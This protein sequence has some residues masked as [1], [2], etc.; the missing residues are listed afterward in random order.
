[1]KN[2]IASLTLLFTFN[3]VSACIPAA[4]EQYAVLD[5]SVV[6]GH[7]ALRDRLAQKYCLNSP[8]F[9]QDVSKPQGK[10]FQGVFKSRSPNDLKIFYPPGTSIS[11]FGEGNYS[12][13][14][15]SFAVS[16]YHLPRIDEENA[17]IAR[18]YLLKG[19]KLNFNFKPLTVKDHDNLMSYIVKSYNKENYTFVNKWDKNNMLHYVILANNPKVLHELTDNSRHSYLYEKNAQGVTPLHLI[20][21]KKRPYHLSTQKTDTIKLNDILIRLMSKEQINLISYVEINTPRLNYFEFAE[22]MKDENPDFY[23][24]LKEKFNFKVNISNEKIKQ[25]KPILTKSLVLQNVID[26]YKDL[27]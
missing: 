16:S 19:E 20:F 15:L 12:R 24:K 6:T 5:I 4:E 13:D 10:L 18:K 25:L 27:E 17:N 1:M 8:Q 2:Y 9:Y 22:I 26:S 11:F 21:S 3:A 14:L 23:K 7:T